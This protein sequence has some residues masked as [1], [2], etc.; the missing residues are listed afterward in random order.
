[1]NV[2]PIYLNVRVQHRGNLI[3]TNFIQVKMYNKP[4]VLVMMGQ[5]FPVF[6]YPAHTAQTVL[7]SEAPL[8]T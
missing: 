4:I 1:M 5:G 3:P 8:Y 2:P 6:C 7:Q